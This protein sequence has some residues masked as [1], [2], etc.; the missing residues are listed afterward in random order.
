MQNWVSKK[1][2][3]KKKKKKVNPFF[4]IFWVGRKRV[5]KRLFFRPNVKKGTTDYIWGVY[6]GKN[7]GRESAFQVA[8][9]RVCH[10]T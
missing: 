3:K 6:K 1:K 4:Q 7:H 9:S 2:K 10:Q 5:N 8:G